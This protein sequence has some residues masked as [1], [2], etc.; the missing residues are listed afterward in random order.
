MALSRRDLLLGLG[1]SVAAS[2]LMT[3]VAFADVPG[4]NRLVVI[5]LRGAMDGLDVLRPYGDPFYAGLR[6]TLAAGGGADLDGFFGLH[7]ALAPLRPLWDAGDLGFAHA[8]STPYRD[9]RSHFDGQ[10]VL[11]AGVA[12]PKGVE[13]DG[14]LNRL[15][16]VLPG[17]RADTGYAIG[18]EQMLILTGAAEVSSW[19][20]EAQLDL[21]PRTRRLIE[22]VHD[23][24]PLFEQASAEAIEIAQ[25]I[26]A[27]AGADAALE[28]MISSDPMM[29]GI[30]LRGDHIRLAEFA[31]GRLRGTSRIASFSLS[32]WDTHN[33]QGVYLSRALDRLAAV[34]LT[35][36][37][38]LA[39]HWD[40]TA[41]LC[42]TEFGRTARENGTL[43]TDHGT[44][45]AMIYA[46]GA[47]RGGQVLGDWPGLSDFDLYDGRDLV[48]TRDV[49]AYAAWVLR[50]LYGVKP[51]TLSGVIFPGVDLGADPVIVR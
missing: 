3:P 19:A 48:P 12:D 27:E 35:L 34:L 26:D 14:W 10:D 16:Q 51:S 49:R 42:L 43:G 18:R 38:G 4:D 15:V 6:P 46:G 13:R 9:V 5:V 45:G 17:A 11:E 36:R 39:D 25:Q 23:G 2:P 32:G 7:P 28:D 30:A 24:D 37:A 33:R 21:N 41:I 44:G 31:A 1:C 50:G 47:L 22:L 29:E 40:R 8:T 20:P